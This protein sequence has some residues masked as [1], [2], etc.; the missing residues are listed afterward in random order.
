MTGARSQPTRRITWG[1]VA[2]LVLR[3][4]M[5]GGVLVGLTGCEPE[6]ENLKTWL[7]QASNGKAVK[8]DPLPQPLAYQPIEYIQVE[9]RTPFEPVALVAPE[10]KPI[11]SAISP[12]FT[13]ER[14]PLEAYPLSELS[15]VG[16][17]GLDDGMVALV[18]SPDGEV[19]RVREGNYLGRNFGRVESL[20]EKGL[21]L[22]E[23][24]KDDGGQWQKRTTEF[25]FAEPGGG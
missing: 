16:M 21:V 11:A 22:R 10:I 3:V 5:V 20:D 4:L 14:E 18:Q 8:L 23:I 12:D 13:R 6:G 1:R 25:G 24:V 15:L 19:V 7:R 2:G 17:V 9:Q